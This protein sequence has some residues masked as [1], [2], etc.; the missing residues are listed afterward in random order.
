MTSARRGR[1]TVRP[2]ASRIARFAR[3][4]TVLLVSALAALATV[5]FVPPD[6]A[7]LG[8]FDVKTLA[9]L[10]GILAVVGALRGIGLFEHAARLIV[11]RF[12]T[13]RS[14]VAALVGSTL[15][16]SMFA[17]NDLALIMMLPLSAATLLKAGWERSLPF[18]FIMQNLAANLGGMIL[19]FGNPQNLYLYERFSISL[20]DFLS[21]MTLPF[22]VSVALIA[23][24]CALFA[25]P[26]PPQP[27]KKRAAEKEMTKKRA[28][29]KRAAEKQSAEERTTE[30]SLVDEGRQ[31]AAFPASG[32]PLQRTD[33]SRETFG[34]FAV[35]SGSPRQTARNGEGPTS[36]FEQGR[37]ADTT[38]PR[39]VS[40]RRARALGYAALLVLV[41]ASVFRVVPYPVA[42]GAVVAVLGV[43]DRRALRT[44]DWGLLL[45]FACFFVFAGNLARIPAV[46]GF[47]SFWMGESALLVAAGASQIISN[48][49]AAVLLSHFADG[50][51]ALLVGVNIGGAG[52]LVASLASLITFN[53]YRLVRR[54]FPSRPAL[55][56]VTPGAYLA[57]F[58]AYNAAFL[59]V[60]LLVCAP[61]V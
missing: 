61:F 11:A 46:E 10:F 14:A 58:T 9:C 53:E 23:L 4:R 59:V 37:G 48:V 47:F 60:L 7:Y 19:P 1:A 56:R 45:T 55:A 57:R 5:A 20:G 50:Y 3:E 17:T 16:L 41:I 21:V 38:A 42:V 22:A 36:A 44:V 26:E 2:L 6:E 49:P 25:K 51:Q 54:G 8:Y 39:I 27:A 29:E 34:P 31:Q 32:E 18:A 40:A 12:A 52:T 13:C 24:C 35:S 43:L 33:V 30:N 15:V 28:T